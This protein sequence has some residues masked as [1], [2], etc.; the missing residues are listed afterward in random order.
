MR[1][2]TSVRYIDQLP[3]RAMQD[4]FVLLE[5]PAIPSA[6]T[7]NISCYFARHSRLE[8]DYSSR[9]P[10]K[11]VCLMCS[12]TAWFGQINREKVPAIFLEFCRSW[13]CL[14]VRRYRLK[15]CVWIKTPTVHKSTAVLAPKRFRLT[16]SKFVFPRREKKCA[17]PWRTSKL[18]KSV[19][20]VVSMDCA[21][22]AREN[23]VVARNP[24]IE[25]TGA[26]ARKQSRT[27]NG[28][29]WADYK[30]WNQFCFKL[31]SSLHQLSKKIYRGSYCALIIV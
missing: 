18:R 30:K 3:R 14:I 8:K 17:F 23:V 12:R 4:Q 2:A 5:C 1:D 24:A 28:D 7:H 21:Q 20:K 16:S 26:S 6:T 9:C 25:S 22:K 15:I 13:H 19:L 29:E 31:L 27:S 10:T 11:L